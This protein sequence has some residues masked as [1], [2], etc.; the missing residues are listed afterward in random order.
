MDQVPNPC[1]GRLHRIT[2]AGAVAPYRWRCIVCERQFLTAPNSIRV[3][4]PGP[5]APA[6]DIPAPGSQGEPGEPLFVAV[7]S[8]VMAGKDHIATAVSKT[9][10]KRIAAAL[11]KVRRERK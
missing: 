1:A 11:N 2:A 7:K 9:M 8:A 10:A 5:T 4:R 6:E 3:E